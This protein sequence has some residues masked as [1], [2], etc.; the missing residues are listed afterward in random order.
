MSNIKPKIK[1]KTSNKPIDYDEAVNFMED[2]VAKISA[3][4]EQELIWLTS[5]QPLY[6]AGVSA[7]SEDLL[8]NDIPVF[9]T[10]R[11]GK[12]TYHD[13]GMRIIYVMLNLKNCF[14]SKSPDVAEFVKMLE[15]WVIAILERIGIKGEIRKDR[16]GIWVIDKNGQEKK[17][18]A[19]GIK[20]KKWISYHGIAI[21]INPDLE[22]FKGIVPCG[23]SEFGI[24]SIK[25]LGKEISRE[26]IDQIIEEEFFKIFQN[27][28][29]EK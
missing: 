13:E 20:I 21:N 3:G 6:T 26:K 27:Y 16:V 25:D 29:L 28:Q 12:Y 7:K 15:Y 24:T 2:H 11:G 8:R 19:M 17:I 1:F 5:H 23:I 14:H 9:K 10:N 18:A 4:T 22:G